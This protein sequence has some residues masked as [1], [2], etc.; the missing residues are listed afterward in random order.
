MEFE[1]KMREELS[2]PPTFAIE[3]SSNPDFGVGFPFE[4]P[5]SKGFHDMYHFDQFPI[6]VFSSNSS[7]FGFSMTP[8]I[9]PFEPFPNG[10]LPNLSNNCANVIM[11]K[12]Q[13][14]GVLN[15]QERMMDRIEL[16]QNQIMN[17]LNVDPMGFGLPDEVSCITGD[18]GFY[19]EEGVIKKSVLVKKICRSN[20]RSKVIKGQWTMEEDRLLV[21][22]VDQF[23]VRKWSH[24]AQML[25]GRVGK[26]CRERWHNHLRPNIKKD[27]WSEEE[28][29][30]LIQAHSEIGNKWA[31]IAKR[32]P[33]R[34]ENS[35]KNHWNAT[36]R[37]QFSR[38]KCRSTKYPKTS[39]ILQDYIKCVSLG[40]LGHRKIEKNPNNT[41]VAKSTRPAPPEIPD[42]CY[43]DRLVPNYDFGDVMDF[44]VD[45]TTGELLPARCD[46]VS[47]FDEM[48]MNGAPFVDESCVEMDLPLDLSSLMPCENMKREIDLMEMVN[49]TKNKF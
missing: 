8:Y 30:I 15:Y 9:D 21:R 23:G 38:R 43:S 17:F 35:I 29:R 46:G 39:S 7:K 5:S 11:E 33:G 44:P 45:G 31:E 10:Y 24:I 27:T 4:A 13:N 28:D 25:N 48:M 19:G 16:D 32:L 12:F 42:S 26:Q 3:N 34:T 47:L 49:Q 18:N 41:M 36:K 20:R 14:R 6:E 37:R 2:H 22:L 40:M 1:K